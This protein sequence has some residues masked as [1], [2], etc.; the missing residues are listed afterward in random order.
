MASLVSA[1]ELRASLGE[2][3]LLDVRWRLGRADGREQYLAGHIPSAA[4]VDLETELAEPAADP[5]DE[6]GRHPLPDAER[7]AEAMRRCGV[8]SERRVVVYDDWAGMA[9]ARAWWL[10]RYHGHHDVALL[11]GGWAAWREAGFETDMGERRPEP[12]DFVADPGHLPL[13]D[14][15]GAARVAEHG[16]LLDARA[17]ER[18][19]GDEEPVDPVAGHVPGARSAPAAGNLSGDRFR[20]SAE[21]RKVY[22]VTAGVEEVAA[23][24]GSGVNAAHDLFVLHLLG[25][26]GALYAGSWSGWVADPTRPVS[27]GDQQG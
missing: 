14:A 19:R 17:P 27:T 21:L 10:L 25:R 12:G 2:V 16:V 23:Y 22:A 18:F 7:F 26:E 11:D 6:R 24:C 20:S 13:L 5:V 15:A 3:T 8:S 4:Y 1:E 9:A